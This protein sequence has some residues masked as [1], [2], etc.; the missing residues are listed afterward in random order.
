VTTR[1]VLRAPRPAY[2]QSALFFLG[3]VINGAAAVSVWPPMA[4]RIC[5]AA[6]ALGWVR[7][8]PAGNEFH[9]IDHEPTSP[10]T[11]SPSN[12]APTSEDGSRSEAGSTS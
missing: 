2:E 1:P 6:R 10:P 12:A 7:M 11:E 8:T 4:C 3:T 5:R 9:C